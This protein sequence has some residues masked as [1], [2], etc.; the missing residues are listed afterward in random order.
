[1]SLYKSKSLSKALAASQAKQALCKTAKK[2]KTLVLKVE[3]YI[4]RF[5]YFQI[6]FCV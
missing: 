3:N 6:G 5:K 4:V 1:V 2:K